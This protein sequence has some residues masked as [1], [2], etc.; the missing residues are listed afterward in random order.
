[1]IRDALEELIFSIKPYKGTCAPNQSF[2]LAYAIDYHEVARKFP[3]IVTGTVPDND[4]RYFNRPVSL[5]VIEP[6]EEIPFTLDG[7]YFTAKAGET[8]TVSQ[9]PEIRV[10]VNPF[11]H[12][13]LL[14]RAVNRVSGLKE[15]AS[16]VLPTL[17]NN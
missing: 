15:V 7:E 6:R 5:T 11:V 8:I 9:G 13:T 14:K 17:K 3:R 1:V 10:A 16:Y 4:P 12:L 2:S